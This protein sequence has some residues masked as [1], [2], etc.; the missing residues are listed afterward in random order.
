MNL[1]LSIPNRKFL[2]NDHSHFFLQPIADE[3]CE[4]TYFPRWQ[5]SYI[6][7]SKVPQDNEMKEVLN[8]KH[9]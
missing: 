6:G 8:L 5:T 4:N 1:D 3:N 7:T 2:F 9:E